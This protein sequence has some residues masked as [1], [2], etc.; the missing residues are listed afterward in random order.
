MR[1]P[2]AAL[3]REWYAKL[4]AEGFDDV[5]YGHEDGQIKVACRENRGLDALD[6]ESTTA[7]FSRA[8]E[9]LERH[10]WATPVARDVWRM[11]VEGASLRDIAAAHGRSLKWAFGWV[12]RTRDAMTLWWRATAAERDEESARPG[13]PVVVVMPRLH[14]YRQ[15]RSRDRVRPRGQLRIEW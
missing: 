15:R 5:E 12:E 4:A 3:Q 6:Y 10:D 14:R 7:Y 13:Q 11:H 8:A 2:S 1:K 9:F